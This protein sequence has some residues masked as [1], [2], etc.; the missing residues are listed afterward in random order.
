MFLRF[1]TINIK[2]FINFIKKIYIYI[3]KNIFNKNKYKV[4]KNFIKFQ[5]EYYRIIKMMPGI[6][7]FIKIKNNT[8]IIN[9]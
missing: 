7:K 2:D 4:L 8:I 1:V 3:N 6:K 9:H 5:C